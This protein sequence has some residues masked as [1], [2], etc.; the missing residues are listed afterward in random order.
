MKIE[1]VAPFPIFAAFELWTWLNSPRRP[2]FDDFGARNIEEFT[3]LFCSRLVN[4]R[5]WGIEADGRLS[6]YIGFMLKSPLAGEFRGIC[7]DPQMR[8]KGLA[9]EGL[10]LAI[11]QLQR[12]GVRKF[13]VHLFTDNERI[14]NIFKAQGFEQEGLLTGIV[15]REGRLEDMRVLAF[16]GKGA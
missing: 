8:G 16:P 13:I 15:Q 2:N 12:R 4:Q 14:S 9:G 6:G 5:T 11:G 7:I 1:L 10:G 3:R